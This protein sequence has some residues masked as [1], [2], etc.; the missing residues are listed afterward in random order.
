MARR[1]LLLDFPYGDDLTLERAALGPGVEI[2][3]VDEVDGRAIPEALLAQADAVLMFRTWMDADVVAKLA[4]CKVIARYGV[5]VDRLDLDAAERF[6]I[7]V[8]NTPD[9]GTTE[10]ADHAIALTL[11]LARGLA[12]WH[13]RLRR[14]PPGWWR[15]DTETTVRRLGDQTFGVLGLGRIGTATALRA[16]AFGCRVLFHDPFLANGVDRA[17]GLERAERLE[18]LFERST[19]LSLHAPL[20]KATRGLIDDAAFA[21]MPPGALLINTA[22]GP[23]V[24]WDALH[25]AL[26]SGRLGGAGMDVMPVEPPV[27]PHPLFA[28]LRADAPWLAGR[29]IVTPH[30]AFHSPA[31]WHDLRVKGIETIRRFFADGVIVNRF[32]RLD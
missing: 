28:A 9:Y 13:D 22:R 14:E 20:T 1:L 10:V 31:A 8:C 17:L 12:G 30:A 23:L 27:T 18:E 29:L 15:Y 11:A 25:R 5:G 4:R 7:A 32:I 6:G 3:R 16:K 26:E 19:I 2:D 21:R 24:D